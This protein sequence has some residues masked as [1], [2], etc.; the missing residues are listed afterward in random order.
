MVKKEDAI[1]NKRLRRERNLRGWSQNHLAGLIGTDPKVVGRWERGIASPTPEFQRQLC[2]LFGKNAIELGFLE[3]DVESRPE[4]PKLESQQSLVQAPQ[5]T[6]QTASEQELVQPQTTEQARSDQREIAFF[7]DQL[8]TIINQLEAIV[9][10]LRE[11]SDRNRTFKNELK[12]AYIKLLTVSEARLNYAGTVE[13]L[14]RFN[15]ESIY[16]RLPIAKS[17]FVTAEQ[18]FDEASVHRILVLFDNSKVWGHYYKATQVFEQ[19]KERTS[20]LV[21]EALLPLSPLSRIVPKLDVLLNPKL[22]D[23]PSTRK[24]YEQVVNE[25]NAMQKAMNK[26]LR[27]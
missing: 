3:E 26:R 14:R 11:A 2:E 8:Q 12:D 7:L 23:D 27:F 21:E 17:E 6:D 4:D 5:V 19:Y 15:Q 25:M 16:Q 24:I 1:P 9:V 13:A 18:A 22:E 20:S 10:R